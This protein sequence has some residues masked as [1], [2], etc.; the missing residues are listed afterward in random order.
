[1]TRR[2]ADPQC[3]PRGRH[4]HRQRSHPPVRRARACP[5]TPSSLKFKGSAGQSFGAFL[6]PGH[7]LAAG[8][9]RQR[10]RRQRAVGRQAD[11]SSAAEARA[12]RPQDNII[13]GNVALYGATSGEAY[14]PRHGRRALR[15]RNSGVDAVVEAVGDH[16]CE[17]MTGGRVVVLG[18][19]GR[20]FAAGMSGGVAYVLDEAGDF[21]QAREHRRW[22]AS[23]SS[24]TPAEIAA[25]RGADRSSTCELHRQRART[26]RARR[27]G[28][29]SVP[30]LRQGDAEGLQAR[31]GLRAACARPGLSGDE[32][33]MAAFEEN[34]RDLARVGGN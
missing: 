22:S 28:Q 4:D 32:A 5:T 17:Y 8:R 30:Q 15:V 7:D 11:H 16:G 18:R 6:P 19:A 3:Q 20:N 9:R 33:I 13:I 23:R 10:L 25:V 27:L 34:A 14:H 21:R 26:Q 1:M 29:P 24:K 2:P 31:A 12:S